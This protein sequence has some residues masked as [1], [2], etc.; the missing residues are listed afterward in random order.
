M[1]LID[2]YAAMRRNGKNRQVVLRYALLADPATGRLDNLVWGIDKDGD[3]KYAG[4]FG[5]IEWLPKNKISDAKLY[6]DGNEFTVGIPSENAFAITEP[7][8]GQKQIAIPEELKTAAGSPKQ[9]ADTAHE[10]E[11]KLRQ[12]LEQAA[13]KRREATVA[14]LPF[15][16]L[17]FAAAADQSHD[18][19]NPLYHE[20]RQAGVPI[21]GAAKMPLPPPTMPD[22]LD[23]KTQ[24]DI[25][26]KLSSEDFTLE[27]F[28][29]N[30]VVGPHIL[31]I[32][33]HP[34]SEA[35]SVD[36][37]FIAY[38]DLK[39]LGNKKFLDRVLSS[40]EKKGR[41]RDLTPAELAKRKIVIKPEDAK[42]ESYGH[43][44]FTFLDRVEIS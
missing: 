33:E 13:S 19:A 26:K 42:H 3:G 24:Q 21:P 18:Q 32:T 11:T 25:L 10:L 41:G 7:P 39:K 6:V 23:D 8:K 44:I 30:N 17:I 2:T 16:L 40:N 15:A 38:G 27:Q 35:R 28:T 5:D 22:G 34:K 31:R 43:T 20:L 37:W 9:T 14:A 29:E 1:M 36:V 12:L 4:V